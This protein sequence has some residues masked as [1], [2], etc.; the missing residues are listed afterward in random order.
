MPAI[1]GPI[2]EAT[3]PPSQA[4]LL[5]A[6]RGAR[7]APYTDAVPTALIDIAGRPMIAHTMRALRRQG[8]DKFVVC[9]GW[10]GAAFDGFVSELG[11]GVVFVD[12]PKYSST[13][14]IASLMNGLEHIDPHK[15][16]YIVYGDTIFRPGVVRQL[17]EAPG[18]VNIVVN[19][20]KPGY[21]SKGL[22]D[23]EVVTAHGEGS[24]R[25]VR[26]IGK[27]R[28]TKEDEIA[29]EFAGLVKVTPSA[30]S[31]VVVSLQ[32]LWKSSG[33]GGGNKDSPALPWWLEPIEKA[34]LC[35]FLQHLADEGT[36]L[37][38]VTIFGGWHEINTHQDLIRARNDTATFLSEADARA[39]VAAMG[40]CLLSEAND[41]K[42]P[43]PIVAQEIN[44]NLAKL[45]CLIKGN[46]EVADALEVLRK[47]S[48][49]YPVPLNDLWLDADDTDDGVRL[50]S[51]E[52]SEASQRVLT[53]PDKTGKRTP[54][55]EY[56][57]AAMSRCSQFRPEWIKQ[58]RVV[59]SGDALDPDVQLNNGH[60]MMQ[61]TLFIGP[62]D[63]YWKDHHGKVHRHEMQT[64]DSNFI[65][66]FVPHSFT[67]RDPDTEAIIVAVTY[68]GNVRRAFTEFSRVGARR[69]MSLAGD[70]RDVNL[71]RRCVLQRHM[72][73][74]CLNAEGLV[75]ALASKNIAEQR[76]R[77]LIG[78][79]EPSPEEFL[80]L[81][82]SLCVRVSDLQVAGMK[83]SEEVVV[84]Y[85]ADCRS[86]ERLSSTYRMIPLARTR[87]QPE[88]KT[89]DVDVLASAVPG[90]PISCG[91][92]T[93]VYHF[94]SEAVKMSW[95]SREAETH[96]AML[97]PGDSAYIAP[98]VEHWF[99]AV[100]CSDLQKDGY[101]MQSVD[102]P[103]APSTVVITRASPS[104]DG[105]VVPNPNGK[106]CAHGRRLF[107]VRIPGHLTGETL[108]E[109]ATFSAHGRARVGAETEQWYS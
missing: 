62:V 24:S 102:T 44:V 16:F 20:L 98:L 90:E 34:S 56:R 35:D 9:R 77:E 40:A 99:S 25:T 32:R 82:E 69:V 67:S 33:C 85:A 54:Y 106:A 52:A 39:Q 57:D 93:F 55:Y 108:S 5:A 65:S 4:I 97:R 74:E 94:G 45:E 78:G 3:Q 61:T 76:T 22:A 89:F 109:F 64:G 66:P 50:C 83:D 79:A 87:H 42:R 26:R 70:K 100:T 91:L 17:R 43:L 71:T 6:G 88:L 11:D 29:G 36:G 27:N 7:L 72:D 58:L 31:S 28:T 18:I 73:A 81:A 19:V 101:P 47:M 104:N 48:E 15:G 2:D 68:G 53:R 46:L 12:C 49:V 8:V 105:G 96:G 51:L 103:N 86:A 41:L 38:P 63:F 95:T 1:N 30:Q 59:T 80:A 84:T 10:Q 92:H 13:G 60:L 14:M 37:V 75:L 23:L 107:L 21:Q